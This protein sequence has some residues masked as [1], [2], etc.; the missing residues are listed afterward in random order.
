MPNIINVGFS[1]QVEGG[2]QVPVAPIKIP[3]EAYDKIEVSVKPGAEV[4]IDVQPGEKAVSFLLIK[5]SMYTPSDAADDKK[6]TYQPQGKPAISLDNPQIYLGTES[7][8][9]LLGAVKKIKFSNKLE[10]EAAGSGGGAAGTIATA[11]AEKDP[12]VIEILV[13]RDATLPAPA[14]E[15]S[16]TPA[17]ETA[18]SP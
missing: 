15:P 2:P 13:G 6:L 18:P 8:T 5:S 9:T 7:I 4:D 16:S 10:D 11:G 14:P 3:V 17:P 1:I 12:A